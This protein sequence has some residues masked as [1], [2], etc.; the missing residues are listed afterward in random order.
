MLAERLA[1]VTSLL[2]QAQ[3]VEQRCQELESRLVACSGRAQPC[4]E[5]MTS[6]ALDAHSA[7]RQLVE[8]SSA[9]GDVAAIERDAR[10]LEVDARAMRQI[11]ASVA[12][13][14]ATTDDSGMAAAAHMPSAHA[15]RL[16]EEAEEL[17]GRCAAVTQR[18][19][20]YLCAYE[21][22]EAALRGRAERI[23]RCQQWLLQVES[24]R[25]PLHMLPETI[26]QAKVSSFA[27]SSVGI[28][29]QPIGC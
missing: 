27:R 2:D 24:S 25:M 23:G 22:L 16:R 15:T 7:R 1:A 8:L 20:A 14:A 26:G 4:T 13:A 10:R 28:V 17:S 21:A 9:A 12:A 18:L 6:A 3:S 5:P 29:E 11:A 19:N